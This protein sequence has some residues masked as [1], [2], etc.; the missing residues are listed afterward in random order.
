M[1]DSNLLFKGSLLNHI[2][3][4]DNF[5]DVL[6]V[7]TMCNLMEL[8]NVVDFRTYSVQTNAAAKDSEEAADPGLPHLI[9]LQYINAR[10]RSRQLL[11]F[12]FSHYEL[13]DNRGTPIDGPIDLYY[14]YLAQ[15]VATLSNLKNLAVAE[16]I[17][18]A[19]DCTYDKFQNQL[20]MHLFSDALLTAA[21]AALTSEDEQNFLW[22]YESYQIKLRAVPIPC[23]ICKSFL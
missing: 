8:L 5:E 16:K 1:S 2:P 13:C 17:R 18:G 4:L 9:C 23:K 21:T 19:A 22:L 20:K 14:P 10:S 11:T 6:V 7:L 12:F 15:Q 3:Q